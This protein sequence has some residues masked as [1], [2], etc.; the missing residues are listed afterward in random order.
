MTF[1]RVH[2]MLPGRTAQNARVISFIG[3]VV[4][5][6]LPSTLY[7]ASGSLQ[8][9][10][11]PSGAQV[12]VDGNTVRKVTP[13]KFNLPVG[14]HT[15]TL[16]PLGDGWEPNTQ[17][18]TIVKGR[19]TLNV[20]LLPTLIEGPEGPQGPQGEQGVAGPQGAK[21]DT[22]DTGPQGA[23]GA[24]GPQGAKGDTGNTGP[25]GPQGL[26]GVAGPQGAKGDT[27]N[28][29][30][31]GA[32]GATGPQGA[33]GDT[34]NTGPAGPQGLQGIQGERGTGLLWEEVTGTSWQALSNT[35]YLAN[36][37]GQVT[38]TLP[39]LPVVGDIVRVTGV[40]NSGWIIAQNSGQFVL[41][42]NIGG[43]AG[44]YWV[45]RDSS[46]GWQGVAS[47]SDGTKLVAVVFGGQ[48]YTSTDSG[49]TWTPR[50][51]SRNWISVASS[52]D[53][54]KLVAVVYGGQIY[55]STDSGVTW[56][57]R[58]SSRVWFSVAS[59]SDGT[60]LVAVVSGD[61]IYT[62]TDS[63]V[64]WTPRDSSRNWISVASSSDGT[65][66]VA[67]MHNGQIYTSVATTT[68]GTGGYLTGDSDAAIELQYI[69][70]DQWRALS[71]E[72]TITAY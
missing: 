2:K 63:G 4:L 14:E 18:I 36:N 60:K 30:P 70:N 71:H 46:R 37:A 50:D 45:P 68:A 27:G 58:E 32:Q 56:T 29:G 16:S 51:S 5:L 17:T 13:V 24:T 25:M 6:V 12:S 42:R 67:G 10:S 61:Q 40:G 31:Q 44:Y 66:L 38:I 47:S 20:I 33:K 3:F 7:A 59:S 49:V 21:G 35:G 11:Y 19:N 22:G 1:M 8:V 69:G 28:T 65:K 64:T 15:V 48:I 9:I 26:Q 54:A 43:T 55:T 52:S 41:T 57:P 34:G 72:G 62:S 39:V 53:G 23:Q